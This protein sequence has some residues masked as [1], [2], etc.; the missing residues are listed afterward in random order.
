M[1]MGRKKSSVE[2]KVLVFL[3]VGDAT[4]VNLTLGPHWRHIALNQMQATSGLCLT[5]H[6]PQCRH[7]LNDAKVFCTNLG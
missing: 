4:S 5:V 1:K 7:H 2:I 3:L 6:P